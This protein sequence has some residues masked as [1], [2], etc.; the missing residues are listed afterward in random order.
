MT[1]EVV[2]FDNVLPVDSFYRAACCM[3]LTT[4]CM[5]MDLPTISDNLQNQHAHIKL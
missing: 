3:V 1:D 2:M 5:L 4:G